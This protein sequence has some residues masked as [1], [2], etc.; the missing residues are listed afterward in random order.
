MC[1]D[2]LK[3]CLDVSFLFKKY[4]KTSANKK[5]RLTVV[6]HWLREPPDAVTLCYSDFFLL[7]LSVADE[8]CGRA[9]PLFCVFASNLSVCKVTLEGST[10]GFSHSI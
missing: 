4:R 8:K 5:S 2:A 7:L 1:F 6:V 3:T 9:F 10:L